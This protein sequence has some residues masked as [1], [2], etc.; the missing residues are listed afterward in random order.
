MI[1][2]HTGTLASS[3]K[4]VNGNGKSV[5]NS[6]GLEL[7]FLAELPGQPSDFKNGSTDP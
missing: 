2:K 6:F 3:G 5:W 7:I 1:D 4:R